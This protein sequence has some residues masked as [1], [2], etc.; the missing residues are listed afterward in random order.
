MSKNNEELAKILFVFE[1]SVR[2]ADVAFLKKEINLLW[3]A[4]E[5]TQPAK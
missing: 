5:I 2:K 4:V 3:Q 1:S